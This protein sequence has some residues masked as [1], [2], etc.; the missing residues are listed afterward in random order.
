MLNIVDYSAAYLIYRVF[1]FIYV[2]LNCIVVLTS[3]QV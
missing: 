2:L 3:V 1:F